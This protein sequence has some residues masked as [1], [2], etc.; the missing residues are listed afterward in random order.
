M[1]SCEFE[2]RGQS[3]ALDCPSVI[4]PSSFLVRDVP[5]RGR[6]SHRVG[7]SA[8]FGL[9]EA[10]IEAAFERGCQYLSGCAVHG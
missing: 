9:A 10:G 4:E 7:V 6:R 1:N 2:H 5:A 8:S 3:G